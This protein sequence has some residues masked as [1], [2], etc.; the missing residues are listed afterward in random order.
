M[1]LTS[2]PRLVALEDEPALAGVGEHLARELRGPL[3]PAET[4]SFA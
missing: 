1:L 4:M 3:G 2:V